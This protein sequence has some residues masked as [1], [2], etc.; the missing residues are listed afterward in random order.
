MLGISTTTLPTDSGNFESH[1]AGKFKS[2]A[3]KGM[4]DDTGQYVDSFINTNIAAWR[5][6]S[7]SFGYVN[8]DNSGTA[9]G[10]AANSIGKMTYRHFDG[11]TITSGP[12][13]TTA[14]SWTDGDFAINILEA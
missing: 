8:T 6:D 2:I 7:I 14:D 1:H 4:K 3:I 11:P 12:M 13:N 10:I 5:I 9:F